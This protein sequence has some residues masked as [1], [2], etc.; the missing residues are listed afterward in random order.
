MSFIDEHEEKIIELEQETVNKLAEILGRP[1]TYTSRHTH[2]S[3]PT[4]DNK[5][6]EVKLTM[7]FSPE[8]EEEQ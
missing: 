7:S 3:D 5:E 6:C 2:P 4:A 8:E 1:V